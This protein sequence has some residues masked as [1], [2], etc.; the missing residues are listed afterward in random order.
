M[1]H[2]PNLPDEPHRDTPELTPMAEPIDD[3]ALA[4]LVREV[5][6]DWRIPSQRLDQPTWWDRVEGSAATRRAGF[7]RRLVGAAMLAIV[8]TV[9]VSLVA[10]W[11]TLPRGAA[12]Q[13]GASNRPAS[14][15]ATRPGVSPAVSPLPQLTVNGQL[16]SVTKV[17]VRAGPSY[18]VADLSTGT[19][20]PKI[21]RSVGSGE[22]RRIAG[23]GYVC[24]CVATDGYANGTYTHAI[25]HLIR[26]DD[27]GT[28]I[29]DTVVGDYSGVPDPRPGIRDDFPPHVDVAISFSSDGRLAFAGWSE[30]T[31]PTWQAGLVILDV[32]S[33]AVVQRVA[34]PDLSTGPDGAIRQAFGP[35]VAV[36]PDGARA[37]IARSSYWVDA[38]S[39]VYHATTDDYVAP[40]TR[41]GLG[42]IS[43]FAS[44]AR[45]NAG[46][47][48]GGLTSNGA[49]L[50]CYSIDGNAV[51]VRRIGSDGSLVSETQLNGSNG[52]PGTWLVSGSSLYVW[53]PRIRTVTR[54]DLATGIET[55]GTAPAP[56]AAG[57]DP[58]AALG[59]WLAPPAAAKVFMQP[60]LVLSPDGSRLYALGVAPEAAGRAG[61][62]GVIV[63][64]AATLQPLAS[65]GPTADLGSIA[66]S[67]DGKFVYAAGLPGVDADGLLTGF[68]ASITVY[69]A[70]DGSVRLLAGR[71]EFD[72]LVFTTP[73]LP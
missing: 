45:C 46:E 60:G 65:W 44:S 68:A 62:T 64:D 30:R 6:D 5:A 63:F 16:P 25:L 23:G 42:T 38:S 54:L 66:V 19:L 67:A 71:L 22:L 2:D 17:L 21:A 37:L 3:L 28:Q 10:V 24:L 58:L 43:A 51:S 33:G 15:G 59:R 48:E 11:L 69:D 49:W 13:V 53:A 12:T 4:A 7:A 31:P 1:T 20:G 8:A 41:A 29:G 73:V 52:E 18:A 26:Y 50:L 14:P 32:A 56:T 39:T 36:A 27:A 61:S 70:T 47:A 34:L 72:D 55:T 40:L 57:P 9:A 35:R